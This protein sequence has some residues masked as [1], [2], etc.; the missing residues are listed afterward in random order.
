MY[1][2]YWGLNRPPFDNVP[3]PSMYFRA[4]Q[5]VEQ[6]VGEVIFAIEEADDCLAVIVGEVGLGKTTALRVIL[7]SLDHEKYRIAF[8]TN[9]DVTFTML[10]REMIGQLKGEPCHIRRK[11]ELLE[12]FNH[13]LFQ[14]ADEAKRV[15]VFIDEGNAFKPVNLES[16]RL[17][18]NMQ[19]DDRNLFTI[20]L[21]GQP[22]LAK[23]L[24]SPKRANL[25]QRIGVYCQLQKMESW[26]VVRDYIDHRVERS[27]RPEPIFSDEAVQ[28][29]YQYSEEGVPRLVNKIAK[30]A[31]KAGE[32]N[33]LAIIG[34]DIIE[35]IGKR[36]ERVSRKDT[37]AKEKKDDAQ[38]AT[39]EE[40]AVET[41]TEPVEVAAAPA[42][43]QT[44]VEPLEWVKPEPTEDMW[45]TPA[46]EEGP[47]QDDSQD[48]SSGAYYYNPVEAEET[49]APTRFE[50]IE[51]ETPAD[52]GPAVSS[53]QA[54]LDAMLSHDVLEQGKQADKHDR[55]KLA[56]QLAADGVKEH[57]DLVSEKG[58]PVVAWQELRN[59]ILSAFAEG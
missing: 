8:I 18:T 40:T 42:E 39:P 2:E 29:I 31:M 20:V 32:T 9:P 3:D 58:D 53:M 10:L 47:A 5:T 22:K 45:E 16:L 55:M 21:A 49:T 11:D 26:L 50:S 19:E 4:H 46:E 56:G 35:S 17:L 36:F 44:D 41:S 27:G 7:D 24:E 28:A 14:T 51:G 1:Y 38:E 30:L 33:S 34:P 12:E 54:C 15:L 57:P 6:A 48:D 52:D 43:A 37:P 59:E 25:F 13:I 23:M